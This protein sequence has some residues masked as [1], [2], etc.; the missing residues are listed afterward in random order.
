[1]MSKSLKLLAC[2][3]YI[4]FATAAC[5]PNVQTH[6]SD[7][8]VQKADQKVKVVSAGGVPNTAYTLFEYEVQYDT[9][10]VVRCISLK[11]ASHNR[12][13]EQNSLTCD[14]ERSRWDGIH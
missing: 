1:M 10:R 7:A 2:A 9:N 6:D 5:H 14:W 11:H 3:L 12:Y 13:F 4:T 8:P